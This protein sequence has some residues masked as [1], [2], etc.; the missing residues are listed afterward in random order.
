MPISLHGTSN[1]TTL[2]AMLTPAL[3]M[4]ANGSLIISTSNRMARIVDRIRILNHLADQADRGVSELDYLDL[5]RAHIASQLQDLE[6]RSDRV[7]L[8]LTMLYMALSSFVG[9]SLVLA[10]DILLGSWIGGVPTLL[11]VVGVGLML[12]ASINLTREARKALRSNRE[13]IRFHRELQTRR[14]VDR[15]DAIET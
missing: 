13:E 14:R 12:A 6:W 4:T 3:F 11:A 1:Y 2:S 15:E 7:R 9:T 10:L 8:A 5:R